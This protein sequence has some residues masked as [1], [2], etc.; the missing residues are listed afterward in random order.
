VFDGTRVG[1]ERRDCYAWVRELGANKHR[2]NLEQVLVVHFVLGVAEIKDAESQVV[3]IRV[4][5]NFTNVM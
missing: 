1:G 4:L 5:A 2:S 3:E